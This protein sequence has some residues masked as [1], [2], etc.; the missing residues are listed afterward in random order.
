MRCTCYDTT[1][2]AA[3]EP[4]SA[5]CPVD[6]D[7]EA[8]REEAAIAELMQM[9]SFMDEAFGDAWATDTVS[10]PM[11]KAAMAGEGS[12]VIRLLREHAPRYSRIRAEVLVGRGVA[13]NM[14]EAMEQLV[15]KYRE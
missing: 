11:V 4:P 9:E 7:A 6:H 2:S 5:R 10:A 8:A 3:T 15:D 1:H 14:A 12:E 13:T